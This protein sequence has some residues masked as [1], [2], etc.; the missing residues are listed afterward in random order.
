MTTLIIPH[1]LASLRFLGRPR[2][3]TRLSALPWRRDISRS[4][5]VPRT[6]TFASCP[7]SMPRPLSATG[8]TLMHLHHHQTSQGNTPTG[9]PPAVAVQYAIG[10]LVIAALVSALVTARPVQA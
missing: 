2:L 8:G 5:S 9:Q 10:V 1:V 3:L 6:S 4:I 7:R